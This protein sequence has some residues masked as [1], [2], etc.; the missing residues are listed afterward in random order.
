MVAAIEAG[1]V[2][3]GREAGRKLVGRFRLN[4]AQLDAIAERDAELLV[5]LELWDA[6]ET[7]Q[8]A[9]G[10]SEPSISRDAVR[11]ERE[12]RA[13]ARSADV[14]AVV[15]G[16]PVI[17]VAAVV[18]REAAVRVADLGE[19]R[20]RPRLPLFDVLAMWVENVGRSDTLPGLRAE[21]ADRER[22]R[23]ETLTDDERVRLEDL[24]RL[25]QSDGGG[26]S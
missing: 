12:R 17:E 19:Q 8:A 10:V 1:A 4:A 20:A 24:W 15:P 2:T 22:S 25:L 13:L 6:R 14:P 18:E 3:L 11:A 16:V 9:S 23:G 21:I 7:R 5:A 26:V